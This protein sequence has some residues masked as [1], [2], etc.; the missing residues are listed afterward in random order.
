MTND[1]LLR[2]VTESELLIFSDYQLD[3]D[4]NQTLAAKRSKNSF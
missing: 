1:I 3:S 4:A 2:D